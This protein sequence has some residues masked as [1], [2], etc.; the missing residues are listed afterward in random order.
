M[1]ALLNQ[2]ALDHGDASGIQKGDLGDF[3]EDD[4]N[5]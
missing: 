5:S 4:K 3:G 2:G 1:G